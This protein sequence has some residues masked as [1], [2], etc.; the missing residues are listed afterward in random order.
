MSLLLEHGEAPPPAIVEIVERQLAKTDSWGN[1]PLHAACHYNPP[2]GVIKSILELASAVKIQLHTMVNAE[3]ASPL[4]ICCNSGGAKPGVLSLLLQGLES[5]NQL[6]DDHGNTVFCGLTNRYDMLRKIPTFSKSLIPLEDVAEPPDSH[7]NGTHSQKMKSEGREVVDDMSQGFENFW[8]KM[9][10]IIEAAW[11]EDLPAHWTILHGAAHVSSLLPP[12]LIKMLIRC[13]P[14]L[15]TA[16]I[17]GVL[18]LHLAVSGCRSNI[19]EIGSLKKQNAYFIQQLLAA[20]PT[21]AARRLPHSRRLPLTEAIASGLS[22]HCH[23]SSSAESASEGNAAEKS[24]YSIE[25]PLQNLLKAYPE[26]LEERDP[27][28]GLYPALLAAASAD[29]DTSDINEL[30][31]IYSILRL[32]PSALA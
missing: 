30:D 1:T 3:G 18:P 4:V 10:V 23:T 9:K 16:T 24:D 29:V 28:T 20:N 14:D 5:T 19:T 22:W 17:H 25:G 8:A 15:T 13:H 7:P 2:E 31:T 11:P 6:T 21:T 26:A 27:V 32:N 12:V